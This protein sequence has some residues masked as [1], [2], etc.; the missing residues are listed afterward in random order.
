MTLSSAPASPGT[1]ASRPSRWIKGAYG[2][3]T[4]ATGVV[5]TGFNYFLLIFYSQVIGLDARLVSLAITLALVLDAVVDP[6]VGYWSDNLRSRWGRRHPLMYGSAIPVALAYLLLWNPSPEWGQ[7]AVFWYLLVLSVAIRVFLTFYET[8]SSA[9]APELT[10][11]YDER[12]SIMGYRLFFGWA[13]GNVMT[14]LMFAVVFPAA[15]TATITN[16]QFNREAYALY[17]II[18]AALIFLAILVSAAGT[19]SRTPHLSAPPPKRRMTL[20]IIFSEMYETLAERSFVALFVAAML[21]SVATGLSASLSFYFT[22]YFWGFSSGQIGLIVLGVFISA[23]LGS[24][25]APIA[26][27]RLGKKRG[28]MIIGLIAFIGSPLPILLRLAGLLPANGDPLVFWVV[29][30]TNTLDTGLIICFQIL[31]ASM[32]ADLVEQAEL[33]TGRRSEGVFFA[34]VTFVKKTVLGFGLIAASLI[35]TL[36]AF[37]TSARAG[38]VPADTLWRFGAYYVPTILALWLSM[39]AVLG[40]YRLDRNSHERNLAAL[41]ARAANQPQDQP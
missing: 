11:D 20:R 41:A 37:P 9:L 33:R 13:G 8:P 6:V 2:F 36:A 19:H 34:A 39:I 27:R 31:T 26:S 35:L 38:E 3:G 24:A 17:G 10:H 25:I 23:A 28:A 32:I 30:V 29:L 14:V 22:T 15:V 5:E 1:A 18:A 12:S 16:G 21:G 7:Q 40:T 4:V